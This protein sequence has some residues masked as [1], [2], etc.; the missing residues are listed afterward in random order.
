MQLNPTRFFAL[1]SDVAIGS[2]LHDSLRLCYACFVDVSGDIL[3]LLLD[4]DNQRVAFSLNGK[5]LDDHCRLFTS[6]RS[7]NRLLRPLLAPPAMALPNRRFVHHRSAYHSSWPPLNP[8]IA[9]SAHHS[10][11]PP[12]ANSA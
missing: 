5:A 7:V 3:G 12:F 10:L 11:C 2:L 6:A 1:V 9:R 8:P 4:V